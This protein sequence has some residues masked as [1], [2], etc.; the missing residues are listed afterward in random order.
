MPTGGIAT[1]I[2]HLGVGISE[3]AKDVTL[4]LANGTLLTV[5]EADALFPF[6]FGSAGR[7]G[8]LVSATLY[9]EPRTEF[10]WNATELEWETERELDALVEEWLANDTKASILWVVPAIAK[11]TVHTMTR[12]APLPPPTADGAALAVTPRLQKAHYGT[13]GLTYS[14]YM[15]LLSLG[16]ALAEPLVRTVVTAVATYEMDRF[17]SAYTKSEVS[18]PHKPVLTDSDPALNQLP[19][20][21]STVE[22]GFS[23]D[24]AFLVPC[25]RQLSKAPYSVTVH[26]RFA[27]STELPLAASGD[28]VVHVDLSISEVLAPLL[29]NWLEESAR[30]C[31]PAL[32]DGEVVA[33]AHAGKMSLGDVAARRPWLV[34]SQPLAVPGASDSDAHATF[35]AHAA[36]I[37]PYGKFAYL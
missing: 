32:R 8:V 33:V 1:G 17:V 10:L 6:V 29:R 28:D 5:D 14:V 12:S 4:L 23:V 35:R 13:P 15:G 25:M 22:A 27:Q 9:A 24:R 11:A 37:D 20:Q 34:P 16:V 19:T 7:L 31:P 18:E 3:I 26:T 21:L 36:A 2:Q 30:R